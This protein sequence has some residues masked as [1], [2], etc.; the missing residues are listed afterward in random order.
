MADVENRGPIEIRRS[1]IIGVP[2]SIGHHAEFSEIHGSRPRKIRI[3]RIILAEALDALRLQRVVA[4]GG[5]V[6]AI[7]NALAET[8]FSPQRPSWIEIARTRNGG[9]QIV[10]V[11]EV[12]AYVAHICHLHLHV[13]RELSRHRKIPGIHVRILEVGGN[14]PI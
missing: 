2:V 12:A 13:F 10:T 9:V 3:E 11:I 7:A 6:A 8:V 14:I 4:A 1:M 5:T